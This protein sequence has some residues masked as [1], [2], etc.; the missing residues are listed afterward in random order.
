MTYVSDALNTLKPLRTMARQGTFA[1]LFERKIRSLKKA[2]RL[3]VIAKQG[4]VY[5]EE[6][7]L[8]VALGVGGYVA[9]VVWKIP[10]PELVV[11][12]VIF[13]NVVNI[14][15]KC[16]ARLQST[17]ECE[18]AYWRIQAL[19]D[20]AAGQHESN[21]GTES[22]RLNSACRFE[23]VTFGYGDAA[24]VRD[25]SLEI[26]VG[27][28]TVL[29]GPSGAG[30]TTIIDLLTGLYTPATGRILIDDT[31]LTD[32]DLLRWRSLI[33][34]V[35]QELSLFHDSVLH[36]V[37][38]GDARLTEDDAREALEKAG[39]WDF[40]SSV[41]GGLAA[42]VGERGLRFSGGQR[43]RI[44]LAR[45]LVTKPKLLILDEVTSALDPETELEICR[46]IR[47]L[48]ESLTIVAITHRP[49]WAKI[50]THLYKVDGG[51]VTRVKNAPEILHVV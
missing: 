35:P 39:V 43:Q 7:I 9:S 50:A 18:S 1:A 44:A 48:S 6:L 30:K 10:I 36:N 16:Q 25:V 46:S 34:Y 2:L 32:I 13:Y 3:K 42:T 28:I 31:P 37:T 41:P 11:M 49:A 26:P 38:L 14:F 45:A 33:G 8:F 27:G 51:T 4:L 29:Q 22:P 40:V 15:A 5:G 24:V 21:T 19:I 20:E 47:A 17:A 12:A 23:H